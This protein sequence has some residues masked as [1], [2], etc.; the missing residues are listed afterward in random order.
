VAKET[1]D[2]DVANKPGKAD[3]AN[4]LGEDEA[5]KADELD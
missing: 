1:Y 4:K 3:V 2:A 5:N